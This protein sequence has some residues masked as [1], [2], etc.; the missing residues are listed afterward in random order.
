MLQPS[1]FDETILRKIVNVA[2]VPQRSPFRYPGG[3]T[4]LV[5]YIRRWINSRPNK[6]IQEFIEPFAGGGIISLTV[7]AEQL[8][9][10]VTMVELDEN[11]ASVWQTI[12]GGQSEWLGDRIIRFEVTETMVDFILNREPPSLRERAFQ[13]ILKNRVNH[14]GIMAN[15]AGRLKNGESGKGMKS[16]WYPETLKKRILDIAKLASKITFIHGDG[17]QIIRQSLQNPQALFFIDPPYTADGK[18]AGTRLYKYADINHNELFELASNLN[19]DFLMTYDNVEGVKAMANEYHFDT[20]IVPMKNTH[21]TK[22]TELLIGRNL[23]WAR[24]F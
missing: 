11:V 4:W 16:R 9:N 17:F 14:G 21:N 19:G 7:A 8:A 10:H 22:M 5:P 6:P 24:S 18:K 3:K 15:G 20:H 23:D 13:T 1:L 2:S 12:L